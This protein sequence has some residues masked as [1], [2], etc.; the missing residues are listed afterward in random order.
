M[1]SPLG[2]NGRAEPLKE[3]SE[4]RNLKTENDDRQRRA[5]GAGSTVSLMPLSPITEPKKE[6]GCVYLVNGVSVSLRQQDDEMKARGA[7]QFGRFLDDFFRIDLQLHSF[8]LCSD[9]NVRLA[10]SADQ[11]LF[12]W[13]RS[14]VP[15]SNVTLR[16]ITPDI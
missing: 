15:E 12:S 10:F 1:E 16:Q 9:R 2:H 4:H 7:L 8:H 13:R 5:C 11:D 6:L 3:G 14:D